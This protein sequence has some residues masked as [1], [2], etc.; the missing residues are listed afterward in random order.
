MNSDTFQNYYSYLSLINIIE[1]NILCPFC[2][3]NHLISCSP[4]NLFFLCSNCGKHYS[5]DLEDISGGETY[6]DNKK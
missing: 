2:K 6:E 5:F 3:K 4:F 1:N